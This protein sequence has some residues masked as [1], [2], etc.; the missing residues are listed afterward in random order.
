[1][2]FYDSVT[3][4]KD[5]YYRL[6]FS[7]FSLE[8]NYDH[9]YIYA[10]PPQPPLRY[11]SILVVIAACHL[12]IITYWLLWYL[13]NGILITAGDLEHQTAVNIQITFTVHCYTTTMH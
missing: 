2:C 6:E 8:T 9:I 7:L 10:G 3:R 12:S 13:I 1:M 4:G 11:R 5:G